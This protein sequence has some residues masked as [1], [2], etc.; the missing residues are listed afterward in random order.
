MY[1]VHIAREQSLHM[2]SL[3]MHIRFVGWGMCMQDVSSHY[4]YIFYICRVGHVY[5]GW[6]MYNRVRHVYVG[7]RMCV[8]RVQDVCIGCQQ[9]L[10]IHVQYAE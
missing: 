2:Q 6:G 5:V 3:H 7:C 8:C 4:V 10:H 1:R 9:S